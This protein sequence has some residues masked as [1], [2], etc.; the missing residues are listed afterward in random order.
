MFALISSGLSFVVCLL[1]IVFKALPGSNKQDHFYED[2]FALKSNSFVTELL[3]RKPLQLP[4]DHFIKS[5]YLFIFSSWRLL[6][7][8]VILKLN[9]EIHVELHLKVLE[10]IV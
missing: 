6:F 9:L 3:K 10:E 5:T 7:P 8:C 1:V 2:L 4:H